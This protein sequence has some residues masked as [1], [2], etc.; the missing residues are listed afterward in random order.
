[1]K[2]RRD[3]FSRSLQNE[4]MKKIGIISHI[5]KWVQRDGVHTEKNDTE[6]KMI[7]TYEIKRI[8][9]GGREARKERLVRYVL[10]ICPKK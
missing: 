8:E 2:Q 7:S 3:K 10:Q 4:I 6:E 1:M 9:E 5:F